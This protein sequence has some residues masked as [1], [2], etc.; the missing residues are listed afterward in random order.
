MGKIAVLGSGQVGQTLADGFLKYGHEVMRGSRE[1]GKLAAWKSGAGARAHAGTRSPKRPSGEAAWS[2]RSKLRGGGGGDRASG[3]EEPRRQDRHGHH[4]PHR[5]RPSAERRAPLRHG[6]ERV[7]HGALAEE[8]ARRSLCQSF[9]VC[10][11]CLHGQP[12]VSW[13]AAHHVHLRQRQGRKGGGARGSRSVRVGHG[14]YGGRG[15]RAGDRATVHV[16][17]HS[18]AGARELDARVQVAAIGVRGAGRIGASG[19]ANFR[20]SSNRSTRPTHRL[21]KFHRSPNARRSHRSAP[22]SGG[23]P[24]S[25]W[26]RR[27]RRAPRCSRSSRRTQT[28]C[29]RSERTWACRRWS[30]M[31]SNASPGVQRRCTLRG[32][33]GTFRASEVAPAR[34]RRS[35]QVDGS[36]VLIRCPISPTRRVMTVEQRPGLE[37]HERSFL[38]HSHGRWRDVDTSPDPRAY[39]RFLEES[40]RER[41]AEDTANPA[42]VIRQLGLRPGLRVLD[43]GSGLGDHA[44]LSVAKLVGPGGTGSLASTSARR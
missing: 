23:R 17:V 5:R 19:R 20:A 42:D 33:R 4:Q 27:P 36:P 38:D 43:V 37:G 31:S 44:R 12:D 24:G 21:N 15:S 22:L 18:G 10:R 32:S 40:R 1:P 2:L 8:G 30:P 34:R 25:R 3:D 28:S 13:R 29:W 11:E 35:I 6:H 39:V 9:F 16:V 41:L 14:G 7:A 26:R